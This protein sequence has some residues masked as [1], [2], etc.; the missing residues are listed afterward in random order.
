MA[1]GPGSPAEPSTSTLPLDGTQK[2]DTSTAGCGVTAD[3]AA[4]GAAPV[5]VNE[6]HVVWPKQ[7]GD[8]CPGQKSPAGLLFELVPVVTGV[9]L[10]TTVPRSTL[11]SVPPGA[12]S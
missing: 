4:L 7:P 11:P 9:R 2:V 6:R 3:N 5:S 10:A 12:Q 1:A 8:V